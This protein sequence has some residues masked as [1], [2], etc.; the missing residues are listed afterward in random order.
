[1]RTTLITGA[2]GYLGKALATALTE[3]CSDELLLTVRAAD[4]AEFAAKQRSFPPE[5]IERARFVALDLRESDPFAAIDPAPIHRIAHTAALT[6]FT[7]DLPSATAVNVH[8]TIRVREFAARCPNLDQFLALSTLYAAG[9]NVG[10]IREEHHEVNS[11]VNHYE[12]SKWVGEHVLL[13]PD[14]PPVVIARIPTVIADDDSGTVTQYN[15]FHNTLK[16]YYYG[17]LSL[18]PGDTDTV[19]HLGTADFVVRA[20]VQLLESA[21]APGVYHLSADAAHNQSLGAAVAAAFEEFGRDESFRRRRLLTPVVCD[22][23]SFADLLDAASI[24]RGGPLA[25]ALGA[26]T[27]FAEQLYLPKTFHNDALRA[28]WPNFDAPDGDE[29]IRA[30]ARYLVASRWGREPRRTDVPAQQ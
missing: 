16:L 13:S 2:D 25:D 15:A 3:S 14:S 12:W 28:A 1:M 29:L 20:L 5:V 9:T 24:T 8:G 7:V 22:R 23:D 18:L 17:L 10:E 4:P 21:T 11:F 30:T 27:P 19:L 26:I 6:S